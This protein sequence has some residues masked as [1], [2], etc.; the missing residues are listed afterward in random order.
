MPTCINPDDEIDYLFIDAIAAGWGLRINCRICAEYRAWSDKDL[1]ERFILHLDQKMT[2]LRGRLKCPKCGDKDKLV[3]YPF[4]SGTMNWRP[5]STAQ[6]DM[7]A[8]MED[9]KAELREMAAKRAAAAPE[10]SDGSYAA[11]KMRS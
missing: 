3:I 10:P 6:S 7:I 5:F 8:A 11:A 4:N 2:I 9:H 1:A